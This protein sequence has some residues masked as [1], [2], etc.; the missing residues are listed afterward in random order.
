MITITFGN[1]YSE[2]I[3]KGALAKAIDSVVSIS[4]MSS[5]KP[6]EIEEFFKSSNISG[7]KGSGIIIGEGGLI[8]TNNHVIDNKSVIKVSLND[9]RVFRAKTLIQDKELDLAILEIQATKTK[10]QPIKIATNSSTLELGDTVYAIGNPFGVGLSVTS[11]IISALPSKNNTFSG[12]GKLI[13]TDASM[14]PGNSGGALLNTNGELIGITTGIFGDVFIG[15]GFAIPVDVVQLFINRSISGQKVKKYWLGFVGVNVTFEMINK[16]GLDYP[17]GVIITD[18][19][20]GSSGEKAGVKVGDVVL[21]LGGKEID[22]TATFSFIVASIDSNAPLELRVLRAGKEIK[23]KII[24][25][26]PKDNIPSNIT[27]IS[28]GVL[29]NIALANNSNAIAYEIGSDILDNG[30]VVY[31]ISKDSFLYDLGVKRG[32]SLISIN[33]KKFRNVNELLKI[34]DEIKRVVDYNIVIK[35]NGTEITIE[36]SYLGG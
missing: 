11:G 1:A 3:S 6:V 19:F 16:L 14:N 2:E 25:E 27:T 26:E 12:V 15:I 8:I 32:D 13:Q 28:K 17:R 24:P 7:D 20:K 18:V 4:A 36:A 23:L 33:G 10:F 5:D 34:L 30:V 21:S 31:D 29:N 9:G 35:R 22:S